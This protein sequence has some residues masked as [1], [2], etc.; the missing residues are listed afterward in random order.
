MSSS[1]STPIYMSSP[2]QLI[3][4]ISEMSGSICNDNINEDAFAWFAYTF[5]VKCILLNL[6]IYT[7]FCKS[8]YNDNDKIMGTWATNVMKALYNW[9]TGMKQYQAGMNSYYPGINSYQ[10]GWDKKWFSNLLSN[11]SAN[12]ANIE[13]NVSHSI[14]QLLTEFFGNIFNPRFH[15]WMVWFHATLVLIHTKVA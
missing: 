11:S 9:K 15:S 12:N 10:I 4:L 7:N 5:Y 8:I 13:K 14:I 2:S 1:H 6:E 3:E